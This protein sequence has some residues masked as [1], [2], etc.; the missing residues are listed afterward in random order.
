MTTLQ[1]LGGSLLLALFA[2]VAVPQVTAQDSVPTYEVDATH[3][4]VQFKVRH[5]GISHVT[6]AFNDYEVD[7]A[8]DPEDLST[9]S[10]TAVI[11]VSSVDTENE[12][13]DNHLRSPD[14]FA[15]EDYP[16]MTFESKEIRNIDGN[17]FEIV[18][19]L[20]I[21]GV[22]K[23]VV[24]DAEMLGT[25]IGM[26]GEERAAFTAETTINRKEF[27]L[28]WDR[29]T[30]AGSIVVGDEVTILLDVEAFK[31]AS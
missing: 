15:A 9:L 20:T 21:R 19:D 10:T 27:G 12:R 5:L 16:E 28:E 17:D 1:R 2:F 26:Q 4:T 22:T 6:G 13:R 23:E 31:P 29:I 24:L 7:L 3:S 11:D 25:A 30:E 14:F 8:F 18:G